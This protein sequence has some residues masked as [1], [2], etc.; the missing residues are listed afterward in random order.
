M[1]Q[2]FGLFL[3][4]FDYIYVTVISKTITKA[5]TTEETPESAS[6]DTRLTQLKSW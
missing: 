6:L 3:V 2:A 5:K 1:T 4:P